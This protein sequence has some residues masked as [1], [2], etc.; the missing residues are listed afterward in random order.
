MRLDA[1]GQPMEDAAPVKIV[2]PEQAAAGGL[3]LRGS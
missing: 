2:S 3:D 1:E